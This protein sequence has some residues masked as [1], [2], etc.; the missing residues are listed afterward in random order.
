MKAA[1][2]M[3]AVYVDDLLVT[4]S[5]VHSILEFKKEMSS[6]FEM[7]DL[8]LLTYDLGIEVTQDEQGIIL[9]QERYAGKILSETG[10]G[11][12]NDVHAPW[13]SDLSFREQR[14]NRALTR[15]SS[16]NLLDA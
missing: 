15:P 10:M 8:G 6:N 4:G 2:L 9:K 1:V 7:S 14:K 12:C 3:V 16:E 13:S 5:D 11:D